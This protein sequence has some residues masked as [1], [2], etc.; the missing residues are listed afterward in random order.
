M[1]KVVQNA[2]IIHISGACTSS[3]IQWS[4]SLLLG[5]VVEMR[6]KK[7]E[8]ELENLKERHSA[9]QG[10]LSFAQVNINRRS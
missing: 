2:Y 5:S 10:T 4:F 8:E 6:C 3:E 9:L 7:M 1:D